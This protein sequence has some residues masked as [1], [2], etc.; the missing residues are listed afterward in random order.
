VLSIVGNSVGGHSNLIDSFYGAGRTDTTTRSGDAGNAGPA[1]GAGGFSA[2]AGNSVMNGIG[3]F[4]GV[5]GPGQGF[6]D[7]N[8][9]GFFNE[10]QGNG[11]G[12]QNGQGE[13]GA[14]GQSGLP[15][16]GADLR[17]TGRAGFS[18]QLAQAANGFATDMSLLAAAV[19]QVTAG[20]GGRNGVSSKQ[21]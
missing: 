5:G 2:L 16:P 18:D 9:N 7:A 20:V 17:P 19:E 21:V 1:G 10:G 3:G 11:Q 13:L 4:G 14:P 8:G 6:G 15:G 12:E